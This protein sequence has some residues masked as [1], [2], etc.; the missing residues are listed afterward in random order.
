MNQELPKDRYSREQQRL[1]M[2]PATI[3]LARGSTV[4]TTDFYGNAETWVINTMRTDGEDTAFLQRV[5]ADGGERH[6]LPPE[7]L[8][9]LWA[10]REAL[11]TKT[12]KRAARRAVETKREAGQ[13]LG[14]PEALRRARRATK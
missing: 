1:N 2:N 4:D 13:R 10:Q 6:V 12:R 7:V 3:K 11:T 5:S 14:N 8:R 9:A